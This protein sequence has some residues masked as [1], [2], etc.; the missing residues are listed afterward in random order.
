LDWLWPE[1]EADS[2]EK[3]FDVALHRLRGVL[4]QRLRR[5]LSLKLRT[6]PSAESAALAAQAESK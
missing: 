5:T 6:L 3:S 4:V 2:A 1:S